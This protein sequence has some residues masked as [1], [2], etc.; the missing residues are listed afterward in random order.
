[1]A[2][3]IFGYK[4]DCERMIDKDV[5]LTNVLYHKLASLSFLSKMRK[6]AAM[7]YEGGHL[8]FPNGTGSDM[9]IA[10][11]YFTVG[12]DVGHGPEL[13]IFSKYGV[14]IS[15]P[16][17][18]TIIYFKQ[19]IIKHVCEYYDQIE[20]GMW[21]VKAN[22][23]TKESMI[24][25]RNQNM[26]IKKPKNDIQ[27]QLEEISKDT[28]IINMNTPII[29]RYT[30]AYLKVNQKICINDVVYTIKNIVRHPLAK[31]T[32]M[33]IQCE[34]DDGKKYNMRKPSDEFI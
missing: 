9:Y 24:E 6:I 20:Y 33:D 16:H 34:S 21:L 17:P 23:D 15:E 1:M 27:P 8:L 30:A 26:G 5:Q 10:I 32:W 7:N 25:S 2:Y 13:A 3:L 12:T 18:D 14:K 28:E 29:T 31:N 11:N 22:P 4:V 19:H